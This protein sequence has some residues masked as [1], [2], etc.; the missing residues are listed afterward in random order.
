M[1]AVQTSYAAAQPPAYLG[2]VANGE[3]VTNVISRIVD[4]AAAGPIN[5]GDPCCRARPSSS[6][7]RPMA[8][9]ARSAASRSA[10]RRCRPATTTSSWPP[11]RIAGC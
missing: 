5:F 1:P 6:C 8:T 9:P 11:T 2:M 4:P 3:W 10:T 7:S